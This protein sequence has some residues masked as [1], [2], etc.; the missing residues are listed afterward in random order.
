MLFSVMRKCYVV[1]NNLEKLAL[2]DVTQVLNG[3]AQQYAEVSKFIRDLI[4]PI[5]D[6][7][8]V[9]LA[10]QELAKRLQP[11]GDVIH[12][13]ITMFRPKTAELHM[14]L[15][16]LSDSFDLRGY[17]NMADAIDELI[18]DA[19]VYPLQSL[20]RELEV[21]HHG[22]SNMLPAKTQPE[23]NTGLIDP[24]GEPVDLETIK[25]WIADLGKLIVKYG[26]Y[27]KAAAEFTKTA[28]WST[29]I[30]KER[31]QK[32]EQVEPI[33]PWREVN[34]STRYCP[35]H[36]GVQAARISEHIYQ[37]PLD[38][39]VYN[40][41]TGYVNYQGQKV[42]GGSVAEQTPPT[43]DFG[44]IPTQIYDSRQNVINTIY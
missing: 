14:D 42:L 38:G 5:N 7:R 16:V 12:T 35:D 1:T 6:L 25:A 19:A 24:W 26:P 34:L 8:K 22:L 27:V 37:C 30:P 21:I 17:S 20:L 23:T 4:G 28:D 13:V 18:K 31:G 32:Q 39:K 41:E 36:M 43:S 10:R 11:F 40:Y 9:E 15:I 3:L 29:Y 44:G 2:P 33:K